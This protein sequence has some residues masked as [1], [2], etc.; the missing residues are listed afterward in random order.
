MSEVAIAG[1]VVMALGCVTLGLLGTL[2]ICYARTFMGKA[3]KDSIEVTVNPDQ[4]TRP[5]D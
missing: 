5:A 4:N 3:S 1:M 2:A